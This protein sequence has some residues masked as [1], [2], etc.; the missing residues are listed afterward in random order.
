[1]KMFI[2]AMWVSIFIWR[3]AR[4]ENYTSN[5]ERVRSITI[6][7]RCDVHSAHILFFFPEYRNTK[8]L[9]SKRIHKCWNGTLG[10]ETNIDSLSTNQRHETTKTAEC[11]IT[12]EHTHTQSA[13]MKKGK[14]KTHMDSNYQ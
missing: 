8:T 12:H 10:A 4:R 2:L 9:L 13:G 11:Q 5:S 7:R 6:E 3:V 14:R 1:M